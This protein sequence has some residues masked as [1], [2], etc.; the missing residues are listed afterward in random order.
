MS[1]DTKDTE[2]D[3]QK[4]CEELRGYL[5]LEADSQAMSDKAIKEKNEAA[6]RAGEL[7]T[8]VAKHHRGHFDEVCRIA[9]LGKSRVYELMKAAKGGLK[10][11]EAI[12]EGNRKRQKKHRDRKKGLP[13]PAKAEKPKVNPEQV[14]VTPPTVT[15]GPATQPA[16]N[17]EAAAVAPTAEHAVEQ[18]ERQ[19]DPANPERPGAHQPIVV[20]L[21][22]KI[23]AGRSYKLKIPE[24]SADQDCKDIRQA[25]GTLHTKFNL[26]IALITDSDKEHT[27]TVAAVRGS[28]G[29]PVHRVS[30]LSDQ[31]KGSTS[32][33]PVATE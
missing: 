9:D 33:S 17:G 24:T 29:S 21:C 28:A 4:T 12:Q 22:M 31:L 8:E 5:K 16:G 6:L 26:E 30:K 1:A 11:L 23:E 13:K 18:E 32:I 15:E 14:S 10:A 7:L 25:L 20:E 19:V 2:F 27:K 3:V